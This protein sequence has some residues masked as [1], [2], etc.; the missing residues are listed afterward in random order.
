[1]DVPIHSD[2]WRQT[3]AR[4][5][6]RLRTRAEAETLGVVAL[7]EYDRGDRVEPHEAHREGSTSAANGSHCRRLGAQADHLR[8]IRGTIVTK[9]IIP[10]LGDSGL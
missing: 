9:R 7:V 4:H 8:R 5:E 1:M 3:P 6:G 2:T 10:A